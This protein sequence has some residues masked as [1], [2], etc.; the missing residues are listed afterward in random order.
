MNLSLVSISVIILVPMFFFL[1]GRF[2]HDVAAPGALLAGVFS[3]LIP[4]NDAFSGFGHPAVIT[5]IA[6]LI[7]SRGLQATGAVD[8][9]AR[10]VLP[11]EAGPGLSIL[12]LTGLAAVLSGFMNNVGAL[13]LL[14]PAA[15]QIAEKQGLPPGNILMPLAFGSILG[16]VPMRAPGRI[17]LRDG[18]YLSEVRIPEESSSAGKRLRE[19]EAML[20]EA[21]A[22]I[23]GMVRGGCPRGGAESGLCSQERGYPCDRGGT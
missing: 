19:V 20:D 23:A 13:A 3:G 6:F 8:V 17:R 21:D 18:A 4:G 16:G 14:M 10:K 5:V 7:L 2:R 12:A 9:L 11:A 1:W 22:R 15:L